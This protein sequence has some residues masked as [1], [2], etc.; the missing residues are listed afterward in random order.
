MKLK[1]V[2]RLS[3]SP[4]THDL[5]CPAC[6]HLPPL[7]LTTTT[8]GPDCL[9]P[10]STCRVNSVL[11]GRRALGQ[12]PSA[13]S[14]GPYSVFPQR[15]GK[16]LLY[17]VTPGIN[18]ALRGGSV[19][20]LGRQPSI[21]VCAAIALL[22]SQPVHSRKAPSFPPHDQKVQCFFQNKKQSF[23]SCGFPFVLLLN[24]KHLRLLNYGIPCLKSSRLQGLIREYPF[25]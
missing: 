1:I 18:S 6:P 17:H 4:L 5:G 12:I 19:C 24:R 25:T 9:R 8:P 22:L 2:Y 20:P 16:P 11:T 23:P 15:R 3:W 21:L 10:P 14:S 13:W 7:P